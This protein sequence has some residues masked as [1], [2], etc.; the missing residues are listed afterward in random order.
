MYVSTTSLPPPPL[1]IILR[2]CWAYIASG[3]VSCVAITNRVG[4][5]TTYC[6]RPPWCGYCCN[7]TTLLYTKFLSRWGLFTPYGNSR[8]C[9]IGQEC[10]YSWDVNSI[11]GRMVSSRK[12]GYTESSSEF[13]SFNNMM[14]CHDCTTAT[15]AMEPNY[16]AL[17]VNATWRPIWKKPY[18]IG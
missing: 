2:I 16:G 13:R 18:T 7:Y 6:Y 10:W 14:L 15:L 5:S 8:Q 12:V 4:R 17:P 9:P 1:H 3:L 11:A